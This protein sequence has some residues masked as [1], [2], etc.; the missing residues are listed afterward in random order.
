VAISAREN[1]ESTISLSVTGRTLRK[2]GAS[3]LSLQ[4]TEA[5]SQAGTNNAMAEK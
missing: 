1:F 3:S 5:L 4:R 2:A